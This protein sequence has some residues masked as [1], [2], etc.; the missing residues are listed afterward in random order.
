M[1]IRNNYSKEVFNGDIGFIN[2]FNRAK[3]TLAVRYPDNRL[4]E[5][6]ASELAELTHAYAV[7]VHKSQGC[8][9]P[10]VALALHTRHY[11]LLQRNLLYTAITRAQ[12]LL[13]IVGSAKALRIA[14]ERAD[15]SQR[16]TR[17]AE[18]IKETP[19]FG[20]GGAAFKIKP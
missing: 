11:V 6:R 2:R 8:Q 1:Q 7:T 20:K 4:V 14:V 13:L 3:R 16:N 15:V 9:F 17:L 10:A 19:V 5:Y 18:R 12:R